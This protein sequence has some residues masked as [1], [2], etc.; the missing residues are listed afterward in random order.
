VEKELP[1]V[2]LK[3]KR[4]SLIL[5]MMKKRN[6]PLITYSQ[7]TESVIPKMRTPS[8]EMRTKLMTMKVVSKMRRSLRT[9]STLSMR[10]S[11]E[12]NKSISVCSK[13]PSSILMGET[14]SLKR[15]VPILNTD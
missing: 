7:L 13:M 2:K 6:S 9:V 3:T 10:R 1:M 8:M 14:M 5:T 12:P 4:K 11:S 15:L